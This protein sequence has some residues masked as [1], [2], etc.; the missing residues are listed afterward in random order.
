MRRKAIT[1]AVIVGALA[2]T[3]CA[4]QATSSSPE[5]GAS[6]PTK[7]ITVV[8]GFAAGS[9]T[10]VTGRILSSCVEEELGQPVVVE[11]REG[12]SSA[13]ATSQV[14]RSKPDG[15][16][17]TLGGTSS[18]VLVPHFNPDA[19][20]DLNDLGTVASTKVS[21]E[22]V[23]VPKDSPYKSLGDLLKS[24]TPVIVAVAGEQ[25]GSGII[26]SNWIKQGHKIQTVVQPA[27]GEVKRGLDTGDYDAAIGYLGTDTMKWLTDG[28][29][30]GLGLQSDKRVEL[31]P[32][33]PTFEEAGHS[34]GQLPAPSNLVTWAGP[35]G[36]PDE[37]VSVLSGAFEKCVAKPEIV[38]RLGTVGI[39]FIDAQE[40]TRRLKALETAVAG[41]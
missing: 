12:A 34:E 10:D 15:Y 22:I 26:A 31:L 19:G 5:G 18:F 29:L 33:V 20:Y 39:T 24:T 11:N 2:L 36:M 37:V 4:G 17:L 41:L 23:M 27:V 3:G 8:L 1:A 14:A 25:S 9:P 21:P 35:A 30:V 38:E 28:E 40:S 32:K 7:K 6:F 16:T 13:L